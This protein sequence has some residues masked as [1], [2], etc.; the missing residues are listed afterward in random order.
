MTFE[1]KND[2]NLSFIFGEK[3]GGV[4]SVTI[5]VAIQITNI[6]KFREQHFT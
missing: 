2:E 3:Y 1:R 6:T 4:D 5:F